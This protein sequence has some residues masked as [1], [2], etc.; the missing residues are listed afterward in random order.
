[1]A[2][3]FRG[4]TAPV[5]AIGLGALGPL[6]LLLAGCG[7]DDGM[8]AQADRAHLGI[9]AAGCPDLS[10]TYA[11]DL[12]GEQ[13]GVHLT[14]SMFELVAA[15]DDRIPA[16]QIKAILIERPLAGRYVFRYFIGT[17]RIRQS[18]DVMREFEKPR[19]REWYHLQS[20][21]GRRAFVEREGQAAYDARLA[22]LGPR[23]VVE[24]MVSAGVDIRCDRGTVEVPRE[25]GSPIRLTLTDNGSLMGESKE[26]TTVGIT[27]W[28]GDGCKQLPVPTGSYTGHL[29]WARSPGIQPWRL[30]D[31]GGFGALARPVDEI[32][33]EKAERDAD[34]MRR[35]QARFLPPETIRAR[36]TDLAPRGT[37]IDSVEVLDGEV[38]IQ[39]TSPNG[40][41]NALL[42]TVNG[43]SHDSFASTKVRKGGNSDDPTHTWVQFVLNDSPLVLRAGPDAAAASATVPPSA[44]TLYAAP[45]TAPTGDFADADVIRRRMSALMSPGCR[46]TQVRHGGERITLYGQADTTACVSGTL[47]AIDTAQ[48]GGARVPELIS[49]EAREGGGHTFR[50]LLA[51]SGL[52]RR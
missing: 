19:Y 41:E 37:V 26:R 35:D 16:S 13:E 30:Q 15:G 47:R 43:L 2:G 42:G 50:I 9:D 5:R 8:P 52:T 38:R 1:M 24:R 17:D 27:V 25:F 29:Y 6:L 39:Y 49:I 18:V 20:P 45:D 22:A 7:R 32:E 3:T 48:A 21:E 31:I 51:P 46:L 36:L 10:G 23:T 34:Q 11:F 14:G 4:R 28:C 12:P 44:S 33:A 40:Q